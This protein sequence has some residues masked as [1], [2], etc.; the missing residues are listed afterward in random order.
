MEKF[1]R[2]SS[3]IGRVGGMNFWARTRSF[4]LM[5]A[6]AATLACCGLAAAQPAPGQMAPRTPTSPPANVFTPLPAPPPAPAAP[7]APASA[8]PAQPGDV[9]GFPPAQ[10]APQ[11]ADRSHE[12]P[13]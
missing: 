8:P 2:P 13:R 7:V 5:G 4:G 12:R 3:R 1:R 11:P 6:A 10:L 9:A